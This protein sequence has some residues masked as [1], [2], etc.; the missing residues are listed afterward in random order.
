MSQADADRLCW[1]QLLALRSVHEATLE[2][3]L[4]AWNYTVLQLLQERNDLLRERYL[5]I[6]LLL[7]LVSLS[8]FPYFFTGESPSAVPA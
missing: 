4:G 8:H 5:A 6:A 3:L 2:T 7:C 1:S